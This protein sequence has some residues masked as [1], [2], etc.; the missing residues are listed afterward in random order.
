MNKVFIGIS[1]VASLMI[2]GCGTSGGSTNYTTEQKKVES[3]TEV[4][5]TDGDVVI[6]SG[7]NSGASFTKAESGGVVV[8]CAGGGDC[9]V[10]VGSPGAGTSSSAP[11]GCSQETIDSGN[12]PY[13]N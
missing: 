5:L 13:A 6:V 7:D 11:G 8:D 3:G 10:T 4:P 1:I 12:C 2:I 9:D